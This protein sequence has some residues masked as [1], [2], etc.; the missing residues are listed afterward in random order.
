M[1]PKATRRCRLT[2]WLASL[3]DLKRQLSAVL[4]QAS[5]KAVDA[6]PWLHEGAIGSSRATCARTPLSPC[7]CIVSPALISLIA[8]NITSYLWSPYA[9]YVAN[10]CASNTPASRA[11]SVWSGA[12]SEQGQGGSTPR[13]NPLLLLSSSELAFAN[14]ASTW[15]V[16]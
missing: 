7:T 6:T 9:G 5:R 14:A 3:C 2:K 4:P 15:S 12:P 1:G 8:I 10:Y 11:L 13:Y 16:N